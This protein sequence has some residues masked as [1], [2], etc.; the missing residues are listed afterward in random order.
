MFQ[1]LLPKRPL[2]ATVALALVGGLI[3]VLLVRWTPGMPPREIPPRPLPPGSYPAGPLAAGEKA[4]PFEAAGWLN[5]PPPA[6][7]S[8]GPRLIVADIWAHW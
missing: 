5:G 4:P 6:P 3:C 7:G 8:N 2:P 1:W